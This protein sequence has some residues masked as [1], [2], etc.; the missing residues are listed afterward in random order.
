MQDIT[1]LE[2]RITH[3][4]DR[5]GAGLADLAPQTAAAP[6]EPDPAMTARL[7]EAEADLAAE[8]DV[9]AQL[10][11]RLKT[12]RG[13]H[14]GREAEMTAEADRLKA[15][16]DA[17]EA[18]RQRLK[19]VNDALRNANQ[20]LREANADGLPDAHLINTAIMTELEALRT[21]RE[22]DRV[23]LNGIIAALAPIADEEEQANA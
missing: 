10:E 18:D 8:R 23:E 9:T 16:L 14:E 15:L 1:E 13:R 19:A 3:A 22:S 17:M 6:A 11:E 12:A 20:A 2:R 4:L 5:I 7:A 21:V